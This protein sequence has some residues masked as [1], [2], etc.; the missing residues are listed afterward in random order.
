MVDQEEYE[1]YEARSDKIA[2]HL[3]KRVE[4]SKLSRDRLVLKFAELTG[5]KFNTADSYIN[6]YLRGYLRAIYPGCFSNKPVH[7]DRLALL[8]KLLDIKRD[9]PIVA[10]TKEV[11]SDFRYPISIDHFKRKRDLSCKV[12]V[13]FSVD[14]VELSEEQVKGL[15]KLAIKYGR[16]NLRS[17][18]QTFNKLLLVEKL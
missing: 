7:L 9:D 6:C 12:N 17:K 1:K 11:N 16:E 10:L 18:P 13:E 3:K 8:Y 15:E 4:S 2:E 5:F 14:S